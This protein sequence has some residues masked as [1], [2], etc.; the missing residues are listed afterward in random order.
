VQTY[1]CK[2]DDAADFS[3]CPPQFTFT[4]LADGPHTVQVYARDR[5]GN[6][7]GEPATQSFQITVADLS[8]LG[9]GIGGCSATGQD[10]SLLV[11]GL[12]T[13]ALRL[14]RRRQS[15]SR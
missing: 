6:Q 14:R 9:D 5:A 8:L 11:L 1:L 2:L 3:P 10:A 13:L 4:G 15:Q 7:D 12:S